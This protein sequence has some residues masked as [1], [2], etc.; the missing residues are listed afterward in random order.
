MCS[1]KK[2]DMT[3]ITLL[4]VAF[5][6]TSCASGDPYRPVEKPPLPEHPV[7]T[8]YQPLSLT[9]GGAGSY[10][11]KDG[12]ISITA[13][14]RNSSYGVCFPLTARGHF[15]AEAKADLTQNSGLALVRVKDGKPDFDNFTSVSVCSENGVVCA[16][17]LDRQKGKNNVLDNT[18]KIEK[19]DFDMRY[20]LALDGSL[21]SMPF[22]GTTGRFR[23]IRNDISGFFHYYVSVAKEIDGR[24]CENWV[25]L[26]PSKDWCGDIEDWFVCPFVRTTG[27]DG[28]VTVTFSDVDIHNFSKGDEVC[29]EGGFRVT[30]GS[31]V[32]AGFPGEATVVSFDPAFCPASDGGRQFVFWSEANYVPVWRMSNELLYCYEFCETWTG[33]G[34]G[35]FEPMSDRLLSNASVSVV[36]DNDVRKVVKYHYELINPDYKSPYPGNERPEVNE[37]YTLYPDGVGVRRIEYVQKPAGEGKYNYH[38]LAEPMVIS[39]SS[40]VPKDHCKS[41]A[42]TVSN[43][44]GKRYGLH[45]EKPY[46][47]VN[48]NVRRWPEQIY[49]AHLNGAP[50]VFCVFSHTPERPEVSPLP[51]SNDFN[52][53]DTGY[54]MCHWPVSKIVYDGAFNGDYDKS[55]AVWESQVSH[56]SLIGIEATGDTSWN[57]S[58][59]LN[60]KGEKYRVYCM[61]MGI[62]PSGQSD[63]IDAYT[64]GWLYLGNPVKLEGVD[65]DAST[66]GYSKRETVLKAKKGIKQCVFTFNAAGT[67]KNPVFRIDDWE[68][69]S[70][71]GVSLSGESLEKGK[72]FISAKVDGSLVV[73]INRS[74]TGMFDV[75]VYR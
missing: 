24:R 73:W 67:V 58:Y 62:V 60:E 3:I 49:S 26:T 20:A 30:E 63:E 68:G 33:E 44:S 11:V 36:E 17:V 2:Q 14:N 16:R 46:D 8:T 50:D 5:G 51:I 27:N 65:F 19:R 28:D 75:G 42:M 39:G 25:E 54:Q 61:L 70:N 12:T 15:M 37:Y 10:D 29:S 40:S 74:V 9:S 45:P 22:T 32:W 59:L 38:E 35:C 1:M 41:P 31:F 43:L 34:N 21:F 71:V 48:S 53:H 13:S 18:G 52:W 47:E 57:S 69:D 55:I 64:R 56:S 6:F 23:I 66:T 72:G 4:A 7:V